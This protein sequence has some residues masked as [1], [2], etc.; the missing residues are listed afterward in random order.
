MV[1]QVSPSPPPRHPG[2]S[3]SGSA[4]SGYLGSPDS[5]NIFNIF[6]IFNISS[7]LEPLYDLLIRWNEGGDG[8]LVFTGLQTFKESLNV[9]ELDERVLQVEAS[10]E[11]R[12]VNITERQQLL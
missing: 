3:G 8:L 7:D 10:A 2:R 1:C 9:P 12:G 5:Q 6:N 4:R 11:Q